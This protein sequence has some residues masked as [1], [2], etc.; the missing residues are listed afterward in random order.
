MSFVDTLT[1]HFASSTNRETRNAWYIAKQPWASHAYVHRIQK[2]IEQST[3][4]GVAEQLDFPPSLLSFYTWTCNGGSLFHANV[5]CIGLYLFGCWREGQTFDRNP[6]HEQPPINIRTSNLTIR[7]NVVAFGS[8]GADGSLLMVDRETEQVWCAYGRDQSR[9][10]CTWKSVDI[11]LEQEIARLCQL[12]MP[13]GT[14]RVQCADLLPPV[15]PTFLAGR[16][17]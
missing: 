9:I 6:E 12:F 15:D 10:R 14:C 16:P 4:A 7:S 17:H 5:T 2:P 11:W 1:H 8:Y 3:V 13:D